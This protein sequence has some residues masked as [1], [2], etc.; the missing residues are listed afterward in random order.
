MNYIFRFSLGFSFGCRGQ[1]PIPKPIVLKSNELLRIFSKDFSF[2]LWLIA[3]FVQFARF[4]FDKNKSA[5]EISSDDAFIRQS[6]SGTCPLTD[7][8]LTECPLTLS[9]WALSL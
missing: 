1:S 8:P 2:G 5:T 7:V 9:P 4:V 3:K 6:E